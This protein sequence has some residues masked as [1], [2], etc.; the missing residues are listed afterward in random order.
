M[1]MNI[2]SL[3]A[4]AKVNVPVEYPWTNVNG[5]TEQIEVDPI[6]IDVVLCSLYAQIKDK[7][8]YGSVTVSVDLGIYEVMEKNKQTTNEWILDFLQM[9]K[10]IETYS[11]KWGTRDAYL[12]KWGREDSPIKKFDFPINIV[13]CRFVP[14]RLQLFVRQRFLKYKVHFEEIAK[15]YIKLIGIIEAYFT[16]PVV[17]DLKSNQIFVYLVRQIEQLMADKEIRTSFSDELIFPFENLLFDQ[18]RLNRFKADIG[19]ITRPMFDV[20][21][22]VQGSVKFYTLDE[23]KDFSLEQIDEY[24][25][26][27]GSAKATPQ[28]TLKLKQEIQQLSEDKIGTELKADIVVGPLAA[29][30]DGTIRYKENIITLRSQLCE[31]CRLFLEKPKMLV[32]IDDIRDKVIKADKHTFI[33][34]STYGK[35]VSELHSSL[36]PH[37]SKEVIFNRKDQG[38]YF[39]PD[40]PKN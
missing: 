33:S 31:L 4:A 23:E 29:Y 37:F 28:E 1:C 7:T 5:Q 24:L 35:Y 21:N 22:N 39:D 34:R 30:S 10:F 2:N 25:R 20:Y 8:S 38:W 27:L 17:P 15:L 11:L 18:E 16:E 3:R 32:T 14:A 9:R 40:K 26:P 12:T 36:I 6:L 13:E 19:I